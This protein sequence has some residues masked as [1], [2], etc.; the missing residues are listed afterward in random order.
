MSSD[1]QRKWE[2]LAPQIDMLASM[3]NA[4]ID[5]SRIQA[6][7][8]QQYRVWPP[9]DTRALSAALDA[10]RA[11]VLEIALQIGEDAD[12]GLEAAADE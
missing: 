4:S 9:A 3:V 11:R 5:L 10:A 8:T 1:A 2:R 12:N 7:I 6:Q